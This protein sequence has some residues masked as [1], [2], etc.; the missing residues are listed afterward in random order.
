MEQWICIVLTFK[1]FHEICSLFLIVFEENEDKCVQAIENFASKHLVNYF[2]ESFD[3]ILKEKTFKALE[4]A[5]D[6]SFDNGRI[7]ISNLKEKEGMKA[8]ITE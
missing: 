7:R 1:G 6:F 8:F 4:L 5:T 3:Q 2:N